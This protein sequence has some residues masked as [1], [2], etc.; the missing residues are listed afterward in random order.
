MPADSFPSHLLLDTTRDA[1]RL[2]TIFAVGPPGFYCNCRS[3]P[4]E[5]LGDAPIDGIP[6]SCED[7]G[8][9]QDPHTGIFRIILHCGCAYLSLWSPTGTGNWTASRAGSIDFCQAVPF[10]DGSSYVLST[11]QRPKWLR[12]KNG[13]VTHL[14]TGAATNAMHAGKTFTLAQQVLP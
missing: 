12:A 9:Y 4:Y 1:L 2:T 7:A 11:R 8:M 6:G 10:S 13:S 3:G 14:L 5:R